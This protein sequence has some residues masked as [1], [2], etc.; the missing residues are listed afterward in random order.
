MRFAS[1][2][3]ACLWLFWW[4][5]LAAVFFPLCFHTLLASDYS[6]THT[7][8][9]HS[10]A[11]THVHTHTYIH[12][13]HTTGTRDSRHA[14]PPVPGRVRHSGRATMGNHRSFFGPVCLIRAFSGALPAPAKFRLIFPL[15]CV[16]FGHNRVLILV[17]ASLPGCFCLP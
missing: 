4:L 5:S 10:H 12:T 9:T 1:V 15:A 11:H 16:H 6:R 17:A 2:C 13:H 7:Q 14:H 8:R 3:V